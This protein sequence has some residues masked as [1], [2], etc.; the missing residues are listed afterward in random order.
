MTRRTLSANVELS[1]YETGSGPPVVLLHGFPLD[2][3][4]W[5][6]QIEALRDSCRVIAPDLRG[7]GRSTL[8][9]SDSENGV[10][11]A[12]Y[13]DD[14]RA[15]LDDA[16]VAESVVLCGFSM[17]GYVLW[18]FVRLFAERVRALV[19]C[20]T[21]AAGDNEEARANRLQA[22]ADVM[23]TGSG[24]VAEG[25][26][27]KLLARATLAGRQEVVEELAA[28]IRGTK[29]AAIA[30]AQRGM[31]RRP[32]VRGDLPGLNMPALLI[33]GAEDAISPPAEMREIAEA[34]PQA[35]LVEIPGAG[36]MTTLENPAAVNQALRDFIAGLK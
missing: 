25:M 20:D 8:A 21:R 28:M 5:R 15:V 4:M 24:P 9:E 2:H 11:M 35:T 1:Y 33:I 16:G 7:F 36:H 3:T 30:A 13:A 31:A 29:P 10:E 17:G 27:P 14:V 34:L 26:L 19:L 32:D 18:Q 23:R 12:R 6:H 22:A